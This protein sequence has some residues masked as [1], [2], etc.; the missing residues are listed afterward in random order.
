[1]LCLTL[2]IHG[3]SILLL[4]NENMG[5]MFCLYFV[6]ITLLVVWR[7]FLV[8]KTNT[9]TVKKIWHE[10]FIKQTKK[11]RSTIEK[12]IYRFAKFNECDKIDFDIAEY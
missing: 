3:K 4:L 10:N 2:V 8:Q 9:L 12:C 7:Q 5:F 6:A 11:L 1:M